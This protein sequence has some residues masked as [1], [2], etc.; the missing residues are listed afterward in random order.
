MIR[1]VR[2]GNRP[3]FPRVPGTWKS[4]FTANA[5]VL[6]LGDRVFL[7]YRGQGDA[8]HDQIGVASISFSTFDGVTFEEYASNPVITVGP[9]KFD[10]AHVLDPGA[11]WF[12]GKI[13]VYYTAH[14]VDAAGQGIY[15]VGVAVSE[16]GFSFSKPLGEAVVSR[17]GAPDVVTKD[18]RVWLMYARDGG[19]GGWTFY[20]NSSDDPLC[21]DP[22]TEI[23]VMSPSREHAWEARSIITP[24]LFEQGGFY[25]M[26]Y[27]GSSHYQDY[28]F[29]MGLARSRDL[30]TWE[31]YPMNPVFQRADGAAWDNA[32]LWFG[33]LFRKGDTYYLYYEG[34]GGAEVTN[35]DEDYAG[36]GKTSFSQIGLAT[37][38]G[39]WWEHGEAL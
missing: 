18:G 36:Y 25:Y 20:V 22:R 27:V 30:L 11:V 16:D 23:K 32:A 28:G 37:Y 34:G 1:F 35:R 21:F 15:G 10:S 7:Y 12:Q 33:T 17:A 5:E 4:F 39:P 2:Y 3:V 6:R 38:R 29:A 26:T 24:R 31:R 8:H 9:A 19:K 13:Y 14:G